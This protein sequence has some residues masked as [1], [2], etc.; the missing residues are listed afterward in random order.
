VEAEK[1]L[2]SFHLVSIVPGQERGRHQHP[3]KTEW[4]YLFA[5]AG[6][7]SWQDREGRRHRRRLEGD[8]TLV[9]IPPGIPHLLANDGPETIFLLAWRLAAAGVPEGSDTVPW[10][11]R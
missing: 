10:N 5:G 2:E 1:V 6:W 3:C 11:D 7:F 8:A 9:V 4:L